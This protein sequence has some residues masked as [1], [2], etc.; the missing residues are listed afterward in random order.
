[1]AR[2]QKCLT[3]YFTNIHFFVELFRES[4]IV[5][6]SSACLGYLV[7]RNFFLLYIIFKR[8]SEK[9]QGVKKK[10]KKNMCMVGEVY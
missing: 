5:F 4:Q 3:S 9:C 7:D 6:V 2:K 1:M 10:Q 8:V